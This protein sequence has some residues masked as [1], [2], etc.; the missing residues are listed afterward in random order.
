M[1]SHILTALGFNISVLRGGVC[2]FIRCT[3]LLLMLHLGA[4]HDW[5]VKS[6]KTVNYHSRHFRGVKGVK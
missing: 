5:L 6:L 3:F 2:M 4:V 1:S